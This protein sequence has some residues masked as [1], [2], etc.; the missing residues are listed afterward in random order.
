MSTPGMGDALSGMVAAFLGQRL[1]PLSAL[2][3]GVY[4]HGYAADRVAER[5]GRMGYIVGDVVEE[6][7]RAIEA[8]IEFWACST[9]PLP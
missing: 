8:L 3:L 4:L 7:P 1:A 5:Y 2:G 9:A 6:L